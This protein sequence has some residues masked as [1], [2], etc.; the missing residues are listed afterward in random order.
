MSARSPSQIDS[1][2]FVRPP[3]A[4]Y[5]LGPGLYAIS[6]TSLS[7]VYADLDVTAATPT[8]ERA[9]RQRFHRLRAYLQTRIPDDNAGYS[10]LLHRLDQAELDAAFRAPVKEQ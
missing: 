7:G 8:P 5:E 1:S 2:N 4:P 9:A 3:F 10:I 6:A